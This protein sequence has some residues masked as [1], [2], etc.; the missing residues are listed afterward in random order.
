LSS[1]FDKIVGARLD[2]QGEASQFLPVRLPSRLARLVLL[3]EGE[4]TKREGGESG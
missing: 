3:L 4:E 2:D 1:R